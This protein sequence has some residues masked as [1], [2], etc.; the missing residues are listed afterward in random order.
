MTG[1]HLGTAPARVRHRCRVPVAI[2]ASRVLAASRREAEGPK[3]R[4]P[5]PVARWRRGLAAFPARQRLGPR[6]RGFDNTRAGACSDHGVAGLAA[7][8]QH[9]AGAGPTPV[10]GAGSE[11]HVATLA[12][13]HR[14]AEGPKKPVPGASSDHGVAAFA[15]SH[16]E[17]EGPKTRLPA[18]VARMASRVSGFPR[19][20]ATSTAPARV[21]QR[22]CRCL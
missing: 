8:R 17:A 7:S 18:P 9:G 14:E 13:S 19:E 5:A 3:A 2:I 4:L 1:V 21:R 11:D 20:A 10:P 12:A 16:R 6:Q 15:A 22:P